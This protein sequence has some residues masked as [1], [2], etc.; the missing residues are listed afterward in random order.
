MTFGNVLKFIIGPIFRLFQPIYVDGIENFDMEKPFVLCANHKSNLDV[1]ALYIACP[2]NINFMA[3][4]ELFTFKPFGAL[5]KKLGAFPVRRDQN[6]LTAIKTALK[7]LKDGKILGIFPQGTRVRDDSDD[8][9]K[10]GAVLIASK[11]NVPIL[12]VAIITDYKPFRPI[13]IKMG[14]MIDVSSDHRLTNEEIQMKAN[15][16][17]HKISIMR[18]GEKIYG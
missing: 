6:D 7:V 12:P 15:D 2:K 9:A 5:L 17:M 13:R 4:A 11:S 16:V 8:T 14:K 3:K 10:A 18:K 1:F